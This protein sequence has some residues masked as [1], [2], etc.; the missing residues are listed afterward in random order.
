MTYQEILVH[1]ISNTMVMPLAKDGLTQDQIKRQIAELAYA[2]SI[3]EVSDETI[4]TFSLIIDPSFKLH[5]HGPASEDT[6]KILTNYAAVRKG[7]V[8]LP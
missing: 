8:N 3:S 1:L 5:I 2:M 6:M 7:I 4:K